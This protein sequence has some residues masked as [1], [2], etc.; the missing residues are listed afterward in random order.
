MRIPIVC[1]FLAAMSPFVRLFENVLR[2]MTCGS[3]IEKASD[4]AAEETVQVPG[5]PPYERKSSTKTV[6]FLW[7]NDMSHLFAMYIA[8]YI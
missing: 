5:S 4:A 1:Y 2:K 6:S 3:C 8:A 7:N